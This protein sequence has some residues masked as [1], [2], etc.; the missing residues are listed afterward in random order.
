[1]TK[2][3]ASFAA[4]VIFAFGL[5]IGGMTDPANIVGFLDVA[6]AWNP[7]L[8]FVM[9]GAVIT[10]FVIFRLAG[11][12][13]QPVLGGEFHLPQLRSVDPRLAGGAALFGVG[14]GLSGFCPGPAIVS[15]VGG[16]PSIWI[17]VASMAVGMVLYG[18]VRGLLQS[19][20]GP[21]ATEPDG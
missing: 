9:G 6:G 8:A 4:G 21:L 16:F 18:W 15:V 13:A 11:R 3:I 14:W 20:K 1:M 2:L 7:G 17:F 12:R 5:S 19:A 10:G